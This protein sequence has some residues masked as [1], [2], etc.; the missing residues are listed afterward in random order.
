MDHSKTILCGVLIFKEPPSSLLTDFAYLLIKLIRSVILDLLK[1]EE[2]LA[3][4][5]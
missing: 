5:E 4:K 3:N 1:T 2:N